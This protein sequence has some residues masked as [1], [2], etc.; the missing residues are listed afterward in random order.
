MTKR[1]VAL[2]LVVLSIV[3]VAS[4]SAGD[5]VRTAAVFAESSRPGTPRLAVGDDV[6]SVTW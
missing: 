6:V 5:D 4:T 2:A 3:V 1:L